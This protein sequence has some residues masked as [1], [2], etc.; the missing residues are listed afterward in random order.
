MKKPEPFPLRRF[1]AFEVETR[2]VRIRANSGQSFIEEIIPSDFGWLKENKLPQGD[3]QI[4]DHQLNLFFR[5]APIFGAS[6]FT[7]GPK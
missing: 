6:G 3:D 2:N 5:Y 7:S 1:S 4:V